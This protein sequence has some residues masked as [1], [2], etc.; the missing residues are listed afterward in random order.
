MKWRRTAVSSTASTSESFPVSTLLLSSIELAF[1]E[2]IYTYILILCV[3]FPDLKHTYSTNSSHY[4]GSSPNN[5]L[6]TGLQPDCLHGLRT[7]QHFVLVFSLSSSDACVGLNWL[8]ASFWS[9]GNKTI[10]SFTRS[11]TRLYFLCFDQDI[12]NRLNALI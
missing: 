4:D 5:G 8:A 3:T 7:T 6:P 9:H 2:Y 10:H 11:F 12:A 1:R